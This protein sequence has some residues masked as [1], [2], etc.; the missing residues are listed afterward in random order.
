ME[1]LQNVKIKILMGD[2]L[3]FKENQIPSFLNAKEVIV[4]QIEVVFLLI[5]A[6]S[7]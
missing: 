6:C 5:G 1:R 4:M 7:Q 2:Q 3:S